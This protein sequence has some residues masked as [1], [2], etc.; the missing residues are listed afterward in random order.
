MESNKKYLPPFLKYVS[1]DGDSLC[2]SSFTGVGTQDISKSETD[3]EYGGWSY[4]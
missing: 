3:L 2:V 4:D 1:L